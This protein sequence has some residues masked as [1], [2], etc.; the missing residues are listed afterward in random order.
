M[1]LTSPRPAASKAVGGQI[2][3][4]ALAQLVG[5]QGYARCGA[6]RLPNESDPR[7]EQTY[8]MERYR[9]TSLLSLS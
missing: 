7:A 9:F 2:V 6:A 5:S 3:K 4:G 8:D 1:G